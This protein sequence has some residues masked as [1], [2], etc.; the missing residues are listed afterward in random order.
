MTP[1]GFKLALPLGLALT[2]WATAC[3]TEA[4]PEPAQAAANTTTTA[5]VTSAKTGPEPTTQC[6]LD[7][8]TT[9]PT[10]PPGPWTSRG[11]LPCPGP[12][13]IDILAVGDVGFPGPRLDSSVAAMKS[14]CATQGCDLLAIPGDL[15]Y[16][17]GDHAEEVWRSVWDDSLAGLGLPGLT[18]LGNHEY[19][20]EDNPAGKRTAVYAADGRAGLVLPG[21]T[22]VARLRRGESTLLAVAA[23]DTDS[24]AHPAPEMPGGAAETLAAACAEGAP[25]LVIGHHPPTSQ[26]GHHSHEAH[27]ETALRTLL[28]AVP[29]GCQIGAVLAGHDHDLQAY[30]PG[31]EEAGTPAVIVSGVAARGFRPP[32]PQHLPRCPSAPTAAK[33]HAGPSDDGGFAWV[34]LPPALPYVPSADTSPPPVSGKATLYQVPP[35]GPAVVLSSIDW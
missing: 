30:G 33:Y 1:N 14:L 25:V 4:A 20:H 19:R 34:R 2:L 16:G 13:G 5:A 28:R 15:I 21:P 22:Y 32:G 27:V 23:I 29:E 18:V 12:E 11:P 35:T 6:S 9:S 26:G 10:A 24:V 31:C 7:V 3:S 8:R 17:S